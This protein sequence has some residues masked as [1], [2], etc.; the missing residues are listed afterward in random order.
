MQAFEALVAL[1]LETE[2]L[3]VSEAIKFPVTRD[4]RAQ[5]KGTTRSASENGARGRSRAP[6]P[7]EVFGVEDV[8][9]KFRAAAAHRQYRDNAVLATMKVLEAAGLLPLKLPADVG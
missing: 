9:T 5:R 6:G 7:I 3:V 1:A 2:Q 4:S 8:V